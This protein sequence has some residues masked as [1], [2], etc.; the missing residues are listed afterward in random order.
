M[1]QGKSALNANRVKKQRRMDSKKELRSHY[2]MVAR[3][4]KEKGLKA[5]THLVSV[6]KADKLVNG[7]PVILNNTVIDRKKLS[8]TFKVVA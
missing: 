7:T 2:I 4:P 5:Y 3:E 1:R 8:R 6:S